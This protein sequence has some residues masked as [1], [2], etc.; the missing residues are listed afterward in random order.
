MGIPSR[1]FSVFTVLGLLLGVV[2]APQAS[3]TYAGDN[4]KIAFTKISQGKT[5]IWRV[6]PTGKAQQLLVGDGAHSPLWSPNGK[7]LAYL[8]AGSLYSVRHDGAYNLLVA[9]S[10]GGEISEPAW[11]TDGRQLAF[12]HHKEQGSVRYGAVFT[13]NANGGNLQN[14]TGWLKGAV[15]SSPSWSP[16]NSRLVYAETKNET[17]QLVIANL[18]SNFKRALVTTSDSESEAFVAWS[19]S[20]HKLLFRDSANEVYTIWLD[21]THRTVISDGDSYGASWAPNSNRIVF[22]EDQHDEAISISAPNGD[23]SYLPIT[24]SPTQIIKNAQWSPDERQ[25]LLLLEDE[26]TKTAYL[27][28]IDIATGKSLPVTHGTITA[29]SWQAR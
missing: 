24:K 10:T 15:L 12:V 21:G 18:S 25:L 11:S 20:G 1:L 23:I 7:R 19:P 3:A 2:A 5:G 29:A 13:V 4:G 14:R 28:T 9:D 26:R 27:Y 8:K 16:E 6:L 17:R 22:Y